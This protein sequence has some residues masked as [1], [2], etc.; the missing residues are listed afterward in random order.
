M[1]IAAAGISFGLIAALIMLAFKKPFA[2][3]FANAYSLS[4]LIVALLFVAGN[5]LTTAVDRR[6]QELKKEVAEKAKS[7]F[8]GLQGNLEK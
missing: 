5:L 3:S 6:I 8:D 7:K 1:M 4:A 2:R